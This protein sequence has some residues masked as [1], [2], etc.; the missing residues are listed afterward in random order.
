M[1]DINHGLT[2]MQ[3]IDAIMK[4]KALSISYPIINTTNSTIITEKE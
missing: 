3:S 4:R 2:I 1:K